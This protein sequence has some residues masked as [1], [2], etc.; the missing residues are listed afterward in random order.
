[1]KLGRESGP[2]T[3]LTV[4]KPKGNQPADKTIHVVLTVEDDGAPSLVAYRR[5]IITVRP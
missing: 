2:E 1:M 3:T 4:P 5:A